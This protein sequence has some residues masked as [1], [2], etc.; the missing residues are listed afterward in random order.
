LKPEEYVV[1][2]YHSAIRKH[3]NREWGLLIVDECHHLPAD[4][5]SKLA[6]LKRKY[7]MGLT[8]SPQRE[9]K[10]EEYIFAL[11]GYPVGLGWQHF[12]V[13]QIPLLLGYTSVVSFRVSV[14]PY[15]L[16]KKGYVEQ[17]KVDGE[18]S[19]R[20]SVRAKSS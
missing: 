15:E 11:T 10:R 17:K 14:N 4:Q 16:V 19:Y 20:T 7:T 13:S 9:D 2:T 3:A 6:L 18:L 12:R 5:F 1:S 8:A